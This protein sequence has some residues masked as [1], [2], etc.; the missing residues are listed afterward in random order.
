MSRTKSSSL[1]FCLISATILL[2]SCAQEP[3]GQESSITPISTSACDQ[4]AITAAIQSFYASTEATESTGLALQSVS[5]VECAGDWAVAQIVVGDGQG[6]DLADHEVAQR[7]DGEW[8]IADRMT[9]CGTW[10]P[11]KPA[12]IPDDAAINSTLYAAA[13][14]TN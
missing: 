6:H 14:T 11:K 2:S 5:S 3:A 8:T 12:Q 1:A 4:T 9:V 10:N 7:V 13:C